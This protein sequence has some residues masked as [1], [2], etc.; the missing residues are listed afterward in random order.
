MIGVVL[1]LIGAF[2]IML[3]F[4]VISQSTIGTLAEKVPPISATRI[5]IGVVLFV[6]GLVTYFGK[7][8]LRMITRGNF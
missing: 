6:L 5:I 4:P 7:S 3:A 2:S 8:G 1:M